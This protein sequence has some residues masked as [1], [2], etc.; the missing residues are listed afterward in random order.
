MT[1]KIFAEKIQVGDIFVT[2][3][4]I[5]A[6]SRKTSRDGVDYL[7]LTLTDRTGSVEARVW[8]DVDPLA[9]R[10]A[11]DD[12]VAIRG[13][14]DLFNGKISITIHDLERLDDGDV[15][16]ADFFPHS[17][18]PA[19]AMFS[20]LTHLVET[21]ISSPQV[22]S[23]LQAVF[24]DQDLMRQFREAPAAMRNH[25][26]YRG[27]LLEHCLSMSRLALSI[28]HHYSAYYPGMIQ[29]DLVVAGCILHDIAKCRELDYRRSTR[30]STEGRLIG[31]IP[32]GSEWIS[33]YSKLAEIPIPDDL[34]LELK[35]LVLAHHG[36]NEFGSPVLPQTAEAHMLHFIDMIDSRANIC[37]NLRAEDT[38]DPQWSD[39]QRSLQAPVYF[40]GKPVWVHEKPLPDDELVGPGMTKNPIIGKNT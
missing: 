4:L 11:Q 12:F 35:H 38:L 36:T 3:F 37:W 21:E 19:E 34:V 16:L 2:N 23:V 6:F 40:R 17:R 24:A 30:Y 5:S 25:H 29:R 1:K 7:A 28:G 18:W 31:H 14:A 10:C 26:A 13:E 27:G 8:H 39:F 33:E 22:R 9:K 32:M 15:D 20:Q